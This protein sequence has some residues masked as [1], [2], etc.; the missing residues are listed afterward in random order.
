MDAKDGKLTRK[1]EDAQE[2]FERKVPRRIYDENEELVEE[3]GK[4]SVTGGGK[5]SRDGWGT[6]RG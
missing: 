3:Y 1:M 6:Y 4:P 2:V 5:I